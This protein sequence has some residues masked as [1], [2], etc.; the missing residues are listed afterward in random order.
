MVIATITISGQPSNLIYDN[1]QLYFD[2]YLEIV[3]DVA[4][5]TKLIKAL[6]I[7]IGVLPVQVDVVESLSKYKNVDVRYENVIPEFANQ[8]AVFI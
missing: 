2:G 3:N 7:T 1:Q 4:L 8:T 5:M 6:G